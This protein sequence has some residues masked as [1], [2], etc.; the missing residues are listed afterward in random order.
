MREDVLVE[1]ALLNERLDELAAAQPWRAML[2]DGEGVWTREEVVARRNSLC[3]TLTELGLRRGDCLV[4][5]LGKSR[6]AVLLMLACLRLGVMFC[7]LDPHAPGRRRQAWLAQLKPALLVVDDVHRDEGMALDALLA[8]A[9]AHEPVEIEPVPRDC[10][11]YCIFTSGSSGVP[12]CAV[13]SQGALAAL[14][15]NLPERFPVDESDRFLSLGPLFFDIS[16]VDLLYPLS[17]GAHVRLYDLPMLLPSVVGDL[18]SRYTITSLCAVTRVLDSLLKDPVCNATAA[19]K[20]LRKVMTGGEA[21]TRGL[22]QALWMQAPQARVFN[23]YGPT[24]FACTCVVHEIHPVDLYRETGIPIGLPIAQVQVRVEDEQG[25]ASDCGEL[26]LA[27]PQLLTTYVG[28]VHEYEARTV[29][30]GGR[31]FY[32]TGD[33]VMTLE[34]DRL[35]YLGRMNQQIKVHGVRVNLEEI[36]LAIEL[37]FEL[38]EFRV[39][40]IAPPGE[41]SPQLCLVVSGRAVPPEASELRRR[42]ASSLPSYLIPKIVVCIDELPVLPGGKSDLAM[43]ESL[44]RARLFPA[45]VKESGEAAPALDERG[46]A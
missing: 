3:K 28:A 30:R 7:P 25:L 29:I 45:E 13:I 1:G 16:V 35:V 21:P 22:I 11:A 34:D 44:V 2:S 10:P 31:R 24:E 40:A 42:L 39:M 5:M 33:R 36:K 19:L 37:A 12:K 46:L 14:C 23:G 27:G 4:M 20:S 41:T 32:R 9:V 38:A 43:L 26:L 17:R 8:L 6:R 18:V 15:R